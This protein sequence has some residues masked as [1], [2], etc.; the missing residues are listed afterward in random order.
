MTVG[1]MVSG[2]RGRSSRSSSVASVKG[3]IDSNCSSERVQ[4]SRTALYQLCINSPSKSSI[5]KSSIV[6]LESMSLMNLCAQLAQVVRGTERCAQR[7]SIEGKKSWH[8]G[9]GQRCW[10]RKS[11]V[12]IARVVGS[13]LEKK[14]FKEP[15]RAQHRHIKAESEFHTGNF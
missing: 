11:G 3:V 14:D 15:A 13:C 1:R 8:S 5:S 12:C 2:S 10:S 6:A 9:F 7:S 4:V